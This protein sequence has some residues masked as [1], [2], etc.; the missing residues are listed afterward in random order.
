MLLLSPAI[1]LKDFYGSSI[2]FLVQLLEGNSIARDFLSPSL[3]GRLIV[4][5]SVDRAET[6][7]EIYVPRVSEREFPQYSKA[8]S[9]ISISSWINT[10]SKPRIEGR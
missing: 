7:M 4:I 9:L 3:S 1:R 5:H 10:F 6:Q 8:T 2:A